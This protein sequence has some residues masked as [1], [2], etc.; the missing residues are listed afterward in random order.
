MKTLLCHNPIHG[1]AK[2]M[3]LGEKRE[4]TFRNSK[5]YMYVLLSHLTFPHVHLNSFPIG[6]STRQNFH[7]VPSAHSTTYTAREA[8]VDMTAFI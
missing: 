5:S 2:T 1:S 3:N 4:N 6:H 7:E 8:I